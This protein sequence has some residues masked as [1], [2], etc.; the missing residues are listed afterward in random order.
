MNG[1]ERLFL[2]K[3]KLLS[4]IE[5]LESVIV[6]LIAL[7][8]DFEDTCRVC[9]HYSTAYVD[10]KLMEYCNLYASERCKHFAGR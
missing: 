2:P 6:K 10:G 3:R 8:D 4:R 9:E 5:T 7:K 1:G